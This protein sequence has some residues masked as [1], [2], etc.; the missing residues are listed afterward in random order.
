MCDN[1]RHN[2]KVVDLLVI[3]Q[4]PCNHVSLCVGGGLASM[5]INVEVRRHDKIG[6]DPSVLSTTQDPR[7]LALQL[8]AD[9][10][11]INGSQWPMISVYGIME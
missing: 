3:N 4:L 5:S 9:D 8:Q 10:S 11:L 6:L 1:Y 7:D 2:V